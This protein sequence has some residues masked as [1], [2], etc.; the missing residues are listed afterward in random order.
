VILAVFA[1]LFAIFVVLP[2]VGYAL[3][4]VV[5]IAVT[6]II[7]GALGRLVVPG[8]QPIGVLATIACGWIGS[9]AGAVI[10]RSAGLG[11]F[12]KV[13]IEIALAAVAVVAWS[14][15]HR[16]GLSGRPRRGA[17]DV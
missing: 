12:A 11:W 14:G 2:L 1:L 8:S 5:S 3:W 13:V 10:A 6:G 16:R 15:T 7:V 17:I 9:L 4:L